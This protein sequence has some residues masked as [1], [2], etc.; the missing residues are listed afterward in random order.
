MPLL[1]RMEV[2]KKQELTRVKV[3]FPDSPDKNDPEF[4]FVRQMTGRE[5]DAFERSLSKEFTN[6]EGEI[7]YK[8]DISDFR[9][10]LA[11]YTLCDAAGKNLLT[12]KDI[13]LLSINMSAFRL[14]CIV[15]AAQKINKI[16]KEDREALVKNSGGDRKESSTSDSPNS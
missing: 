12:A 9:A 2:L 5:R 15:D 6:K 7:D 11:V 1:N 16:T 8:R 10:K 14:E 13:E 3:V 4:V